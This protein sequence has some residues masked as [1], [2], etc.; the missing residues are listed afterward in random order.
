MSLTFKYD[1]VVNNAAFSLISEGLIPRHLRRS[2][3][4]I[5]CMSEYLHKSHK[6]AVLM[7]HLVFPAKF[8]G[9]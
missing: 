5:W 8:R 3:N 4:V 7:Y 1:F 9:Q 6:V 2:S